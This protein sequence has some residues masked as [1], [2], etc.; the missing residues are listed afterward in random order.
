MVT[1]KSI[2]ITFL[3]NEAQ[4]LRQWLKALLL[5]EIHTSAYYA[6]LEYFSKCNR[7]YRLGS[8]GVI[9]MRLEISACLSLIEMLRYT[10][11]LKQDSD[12]TLHIGND[13]VH[14]DFEIYGIEA[15][16]DAIEMQ[17]NNAFR[18]KVKKNR[19]KRL[20]YA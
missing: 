14:F 4:F 8:V 2:P 20:L 12:N 5:N 11:S 9:K 17:Y 1:R 19:K 7:Y 15:L 18:T 10:V 13:I 6:V 16:A 3:P